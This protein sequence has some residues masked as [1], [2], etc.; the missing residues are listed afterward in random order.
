GRLVGLLDYKSLPTNNGIE[1]GSAEHRRAWESG[2]IE[3]FGR[4]SFSNIQQQLELNI[5][6]LPTDYH[7]SQERQITPEKTTGILKKSTK[8]TTSP[9]ENAG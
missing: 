9:P 7:P 4:D 6:H 8:Q 2:H 1:I 3:Y 5:N